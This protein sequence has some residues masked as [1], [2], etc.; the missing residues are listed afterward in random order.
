MKKQLMF[1]LF[2]LGIV[3]GAGFVNAR[4]NT[5]GISV[6]VSG[7]TVSLNSGCTPRGCSAV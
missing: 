5:Q 2:V 1:A 4:S 3:F 6:H 7:D